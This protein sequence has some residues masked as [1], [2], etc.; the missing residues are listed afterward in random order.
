MDDCSMMLDD[1]F[2]SID[3]IKHID[4]KSFNKVMDIYKAKCK[5]HLDFGN[6]TLP[7]QITLA[8]LTL[9]DLE[10]LSQKINSITK[11][12]FK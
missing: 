2:S 8:N 10:A 7:L 3:L 4:D 6:K 12:K 9:I 5:E 11:I 1:I